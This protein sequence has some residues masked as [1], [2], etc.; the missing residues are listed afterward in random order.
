MI[1]FSNIQASFSD[2]SLRYLK[3]KWQVNIGS[4][5]I[6]R[7]S[8]HQAASHYL[9]QYWPRSRSTL[10]YGITGQQWVKSGNHSVVSMFIIF[11][12]LWQYI[13][14]I[15]RCRWMRTQTG[16]LRDFGQNCT[17]DVCKTASFYWPQMNATWPHWCN[18]LLPEPIMTKICAT[19]WRH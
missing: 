12:L 14:C 5:K 7:A 10:P 19:T 15:Y 17:W 3:W 16:V 9:S 1:F 8:C 4:R 13:V 18:K 11:K 2:W 6:V